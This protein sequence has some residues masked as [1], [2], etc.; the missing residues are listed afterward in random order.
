MGKTLVI[1]ESP[2]KAKTIGKFLGSKYK[3]VASVGQV[4]DLP[5]SKLGIDID[6]R[7]EPQYISIRGK[8]DVIKT[9]RK[10]AK[11]ADKVYLATD[12]DREGE[13]IS[14]HIAHLLGMDGSK[15]CRIEF[16]EITK[17]AIQTAVKHPRAINQNLVDAQQARRVLDRLVGY[18]I[19]PLLW[20]KI[21]R[22]LSAGRV[23]SAALK[24]IC[25]RE[26]LILDFVPKEYWTISAILQKPEEKGKKK[27]QFTAK[28]TEHN[29]KKITVETKE[30]AD[31]ILAALDPNGFFVKSV[32][33]KEQLLIPR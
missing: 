1:V 17:G 16:N 33:L 8:G 31:A 5:K 24:I 26:K 4:R 29:G 9:M 18:Q 27:K 22:G 14:W 3:V 12:P 7:F 25:D 11:D 10:E 30:Q 19:S 6:N 20:R 23:Q 13:A 28:L 2:S 15:P 21:H 32:D